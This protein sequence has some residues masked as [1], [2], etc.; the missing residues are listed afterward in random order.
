MREHRPHPESIRSPLAVKRIITASKAYWV[1]TARSAPGP[2]GFTGQRSWV[3]PGRDAT[4]GR[5]RPATAEDKIPSAAFPPLR[6]SAHPMHSL[7]RIAPSP[8]VKE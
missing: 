3:P 5:A 2:K 8:D 1:R 7:R 6:G 4:F